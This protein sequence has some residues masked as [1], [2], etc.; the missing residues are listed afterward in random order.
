MKVSVSL[1]LVPLLAAST[2]AQTLPP[3][4]SLDEAIRIAR[5][6]RPA[7]LETLNDAEVDKANERAARSKYLPT[8]SIGFNTDAAPSRSYNHLTDSTR[9][10]RSSETSIGVGLSMVLLDNGS[11]RND[12]RTARLNADRTTIAVEQAEISLRTDVTNRY[13]AVVLADRTI[14]IEERNLEKQKQNLEDTQTRYTIAGASEVNVRN[15]RISMRRSENQLANA[16]DAVRQRKIELLEAMGLPVDREIQVDT[17]VPTP[18]DPSRLLPESLVAQALQL[19]PSLRLTGIGLTSQDLSTRLARTSRWR[20]TVSASANYSRRIGADD[21][22]GFLDPNLRDSNFGF[23]LTA[24]YDFPEW[25]SSTARV[26][27][28]EAALADA[29]LERRRNALQV[30]RQILSQLVDLRAAARSLALAELE[31]EETREIILIAEEGL[32]A[33][34]VT[35]FEYQNYLDQAATAERSVLQARLQTI[36]RQLTLEQTIGAPL[37]P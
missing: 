13:F 16:H 32:R 27:S 11:R 2:T 22:G 9:F 20:P 3:V 12:V 31:R 18:I 1:I 28:A 10:S 8:P 21:Y 37:R 19:N 5:E 35:S 17:I 4:L 36:T 33:G 6:N 30:E 29:Q 26:T 23:R 25:F 7:Y 15:A 24:G 34:R 14:A